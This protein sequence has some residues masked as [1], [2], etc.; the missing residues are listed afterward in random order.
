MQLDIFTALAADTECSCDTC[1]DGEI[2]HQPPTDDDT[3]EMEI[4]R[5]RNLSGA[6]VAF[7]EDA[8]SCMEE[9]RRDLGATNRYDWADHF[10][11]GKTYVETTRRVL[12]GALDR[13]DVEEL[14]EMSLSLVWN[15][16]DLDFAER[17]ARRSALTT[18]EKLTAALE[19]RSPRKIKH[20]ECDA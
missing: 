16:K 7:I 10:V 5:V 20:S 3:T 13:L 17:S 15:D 9:S 14:V 19:G 11:E 12:E 4:I 6:A 18:Q 8:F 2:V 1:I